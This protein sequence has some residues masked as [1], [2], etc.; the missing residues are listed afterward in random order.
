M[1]SFFGSSTK[2]EKGEAFGWRTFISYQ[3]PGGANCPWASAG[4]KALCLGENSGHFQA[5]QGV[6]RK[7][8]AARTA[9]MRSL[10]HAGGLTAAAQAFVADLPRKPKGG[11][12]KVAIRVNGTSDLP[13]LADA[14]ERAARER[15]VEARFY[16]YTKSLRAALAWVKGTSKV[17]RTFSL[18][19]GNW[20]DARTVL[21]AGGNVAAIVESSEVAELLAEY[22]GAAGIVDGDEHDLRFLDPDQRGKGPG[23]LVVLT[24]KGKRARL[25]GT[26]M[27]V[28]MAQ[29]WTAYGFS[30]AA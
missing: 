17:H 21:A 10:L 12:S 14:V 16:D 19:E 4:C 8:Q 25:D 2:V 23:F 24:P 9:R 28:R 29:L 6:A 22:L 27:V 18:S 15:G 5:A 20:A 1:T 13:L 7:A 3:V 26:G 11:W 30:S